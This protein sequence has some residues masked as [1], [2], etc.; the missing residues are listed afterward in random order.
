MIEILRPGWSDKAREALGPS[1]ARDDPEED[2][3][4]PETGL[5]RGD[6]EVA[7]HRKLE[8]A[9]EGVAGYRCD[10]WATDLHAGRP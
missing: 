10:R 5:R 9:A 2:L 4:L 8:P 1:A 3:G 7:P 6:P